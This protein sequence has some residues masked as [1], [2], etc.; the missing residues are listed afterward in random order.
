MKPVIDHRVNKTSGWSCGGRPLHG[1]QAAM[2]T[3]AFED[4]YFKVC[5][6][7]Y[8]RMRPGMKALSELMARTTRCTLPGRERT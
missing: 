3:E 1:Q 6:L 2:S 4:F 7:D 8:A 5:T